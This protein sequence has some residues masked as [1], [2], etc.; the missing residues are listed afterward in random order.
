M[1]HLET[2][3]AIYEAFGRGDIPALMNHISDDIDWEPELTNRGVPWLN[4]GRGKEHVLKFFGAVGGGMD[5]K[6]FEV[7]NML[8]GGNQVAV[9][10]RL[11]ATV[12]AT[13]KPL[14]DT[15]CH[16]WTFGADGKAIAMRHFVDTTSHG[17]AA[18]VL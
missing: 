18:G 15:E 8:A 9:I 16:V 2:A 5:M 13:G 3:Q 4:P 12:R 17:I 14:D 6:S 11:S 7:R 10:V 1:A